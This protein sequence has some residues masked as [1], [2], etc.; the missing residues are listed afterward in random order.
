MAVHVVAGMDAV[1]SVC[2]IACLYLLCI[3]DHVDIRSVYEKAVFTQC[4]LPTLHTSG[5][6]RHTCTC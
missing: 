1:L 2:W 3:V 6:I 4:A 5:I